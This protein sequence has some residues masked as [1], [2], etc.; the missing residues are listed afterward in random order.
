MSEKTIEPAASSAL[1]S[2]KIGLA[3]ILLVA[4]IA[5]FYVLA[6]EPLFMRI[7]ALLVPLLAHLG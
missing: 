4:G 2:A 3:I 5:A 6:K 7:G 1:E